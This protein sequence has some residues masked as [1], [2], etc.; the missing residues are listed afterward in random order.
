MALSVNGK[1]CEWAA[2]ELCDRLHTLL[3]ADNEQVGNQQRARWHLERRDQRRR[4]LDA[5]ASAFCGRP[6]TGYG[7]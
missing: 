5:A 4:E 6:V 7:P 3:V 2:M 1:R